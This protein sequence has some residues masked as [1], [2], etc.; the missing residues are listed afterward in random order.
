MA[1]KSDLAEI[2]GVGSPIKR[3][4]KGKLKVI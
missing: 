1:K 4:K 3:G 2:K